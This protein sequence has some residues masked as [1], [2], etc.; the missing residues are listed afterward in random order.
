MVLAFFPRWHVCSA[1][2]LSFCALVLAGCGGPAVTR[3]ALNGSVEPAKAFALP[4][5][6]GPAVTGVIERTYSNAIQQEIVLASD[7]AVSGQNMIRIQIFG[8]T[9]QSAGTSRAGDPFLASSDIGRELRAYFPGVAMRRSPLYAQ[10][11]YGPF[12]YA[13]GTHGSGDMC[14]YGWQRMTSAKNAGPFSPQGSIQVR[15]RICQRGA[16]E[17]SLLAMMYGYTI[18]ASLPGGWNPYGNAPDPDPR[19]GR[20]GQTVNPADGSW[21]DGMAEPAPQPAVRRTVRTSASPSPKPA[22]EAVPAPPAGA[23]VVP[24]PPGE[25]SVPIVPAPPPGGG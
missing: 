22:A 24:P 12:G 2:T 21:V 19:L 20:T 15:M 23:P 3:H 7:T 16:T 11:S 4:P 9:G 13:V 17:R 18:N 6:G 5:P 1:A 8:R 10:N 14:L 25:G